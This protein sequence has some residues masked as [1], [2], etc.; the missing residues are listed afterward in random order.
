MIPTWLRPPWSTHH[1]FCGIT[2]RCQVLRVE[3]PARDHMTGR[4]FC[5]DERL[6]V[7][8]LGDKIAL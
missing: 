7:P 2:M 8:N 4:D 6:E 3:R 1:F 5:V